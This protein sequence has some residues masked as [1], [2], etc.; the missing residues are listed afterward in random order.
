MASIW[1][2]D[3]QIVKHSIRNSYVIPRFPDL[4]YNVDGVVANCNGKY[5]RRFPGEDYELSLVYFQLTCFCGSIV[6]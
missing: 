5:W 1:H 2:S 3:W 6:S 4:G